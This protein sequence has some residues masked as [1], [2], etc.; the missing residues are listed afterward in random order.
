[1]TFILVLNSFY[2]IFPSWKLGNKNSKPY[3]FAGIMYNT[4]P[5]IRNIIKKNTAY[6]TFY[7][8]LSYKAYE[9][10]S[11]NIT[12]KEYLAIL[13]RNYVH[14]NFKQLI[15]LDLKKNLF[16]YVIVGAIP[17]QKNI[18]NYLIQRGWKKVEIK[19]NKKHNTK[20]YLFKK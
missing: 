3:R 7:V 5:I 16:D 6:R 8:G 14:D 15:D 11:Q 12:I 10:F 2:L 1:M 18:I 17:N 19:T 20:A 9:F 13:K 4:Q